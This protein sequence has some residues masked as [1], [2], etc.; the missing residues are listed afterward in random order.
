MPS[1]DEHLEKAK[2]NETFAEFLATKTK[3]HDWAATVLY[4]AALHYVDAI[5][6]VSQVDPPDHEQRHA[7]IR[8]ND[9]LRRIYAEYRMLETLSRNA[10]YFALPVTENDWNR[11]KPE[12][13]ALRGH[14]RSRLG[15][16]D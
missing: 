9:T 3:Y 4:Y 14:I 1:K 15:V 10:R 12:F 2:R 7:L 6:A 11:V 16:K 5:L 8:R 13:D